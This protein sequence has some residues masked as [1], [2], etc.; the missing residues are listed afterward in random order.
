MSKPITTSNPLDP[1]EWVDAPAEFTEGT[2]DLAGYWESASPKTAK[3]DATFGSPPVTFTPLY[4]TLT[5]SDIDPEKTS[6]L[7][8]CRLEA[9]AILRSANKDEG[10]IE[11]PAGT[12]FGIWAKPGMREL[13]K[14]A[15]RKLWMRN[16]QKVR[17]D[18]VYFKEIGQ[19][20]PMVVFTI[21]WA[22]GTTTE[23]LKVR[24]DYRNESLDDA[25][26]ERKNR[27]AKRAAEK[28]ASDDGGEDDF[29]PF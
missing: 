11:F 12:L 9:P 6:T 29:I 24:E 3:R 7:I 16:G 4:V 5:D 22:E 17:N 21:R 8:H 1:Q 18:V 19:Q 14:Y 10:Y 23:A 2:G 25:A 28:A 20:S 26:M 13:K 15:N 27:R